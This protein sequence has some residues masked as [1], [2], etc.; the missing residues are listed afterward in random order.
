MHDISTLLEN[1]P[2][3]GLFIFLILGGFGL[4]FPEDAVLIACGFLI[5][6]HVVKPVPSILIV[7]AGM[8]IA[9]NLLY[10]LGRN[11]GRKM[12]LS[13]WFKRFMP[14]ERLKVLEEKF[15][16]KGVI[17]IL[18][19]R[20]LIG[21]RAQIFFVAGIMGMP[22]TKFILADTISAIFTITIMVSAGYMGGNSLKAIEHGVLKVEYIIV[23]VFIG[24]LIIYLFYKF[25][26]QRK[27][28]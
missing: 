22:L 25:F 5:S 15:K 17:F 2:Y 6:N 3:I 10:F 23:L 21:L 28:K 19:G 27:M 11:Y 14:P 24:S 20:H 1:F 16:N 18:L 26:Q 12:V 9:D 13:G 8:L 4:P 7:Y